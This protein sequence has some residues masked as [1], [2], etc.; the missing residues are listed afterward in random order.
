MSMIYVQPR[1][2]KSR[3]IAEHAEYCFEDF[4]KF[5]RAHG[6]NLELGTFA[7]A[8][9]LDSNWRSLVKGHQRA[10]SSFAGK[11]SVHGVFQ[12]ICIHSN[13]SKIAK[14]SKQRILR[15]M[16]IAQ[17]LNAKYVVF[18]ANFNPFV[19]G[20]LYR[21]NWIARNA[22]FWREV[23]GN[24]EATVLL[25]NFWEPS[26]EILK[27]L[28]NEVNM[29]RLKVCL[30]TGHINAFSKVPI[31]EWVA[32]LGKQI[33]YMHFSDNMGNSDQHLQ[34]GCGNINWQA[35]TAVLEKHRVNPEIVLETETIRKTD[36]S[37]T[38]LETNKVYPFNR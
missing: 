31:E 17:S 24:Y 29:S 38:Y 22:A 18:H 14:V 21:S 6:C 16:D 26:P 7:Y 12:D 32:K 15:N 30:D 36:E 4:L 27:K 8:N 33:P 11:V 34:I 13:D 25:E 28:L 9:A 10:L 3:G 35:L 19:Y 20:E 37:L 23:L 2:W 1:I 5:A